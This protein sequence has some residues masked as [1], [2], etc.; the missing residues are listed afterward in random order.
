MG[1]IVASGLGTLRL[2]SKLLVLGLCLGLNASH[3]FA[4]DDESA[5]T[6]PTEP[7]PTETPSSDTP[8]TET[9]APPQEPAAVE[10]KE[11]GVIKEKIEE[12]KK[13]RIKN[14]KETTDAVLKRRGKEPEAVKYSLVGAAQTLPEKVIRVVYARRNIVSKESFEQSGGAK[15]DIGIDVVANINAYA[16]QYGLTDKISLQ[17]LI[18]QVAENS[19]TIDADKFRKSQIYAK[20]YKETM[21]AVIPTFIQNGV[22]GTSGTDEEKYNDCLTQINSGDV[23]LATNQKMMLLTGEIYTVPKGASVKEI[24]D[25][26]VT[27]NARPSQGKTGLSDITVGAMYSVFSSP[28]MNFS[29]AVGLRL[30]TSKADDEKSFNRTGSGFTT[31]GIQLAYDYKVADP[32]IISLTQSLEHHLKNPSYKRHS[33][34]NPDQ[35]LSDS[36]KDPLDPDSG[37]PDPNS[38]GDEGIPGRGDGVDTEFEVSRKLDSSAGSLRFAFALGALAPVLS[39]LTTTVSYNWSHDPATSWDGVDQDNGSGSRSY[40]YTLNFDGLGLRPRL[41]FGVSLAQD[42]Y[43]SGYGLPAAGVTSTFSLA[44]YYKF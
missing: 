40:S 21:D 27:S 37:A 33:H 7:T 16:I 6:P 39:P 1:T 25:R 38:A 34:I 31:L 42:R 8:S 9:P 28:I 2:T 3:A 22:C 43:I 4:Q 12:I 23:K 24:A 18:P 29:T 11:P 26:L 10:E 14:R 17:V 15:K 41:P 44:G 13:S 5:P 19:T 35:L 30:P 36:L 32:F 20:K